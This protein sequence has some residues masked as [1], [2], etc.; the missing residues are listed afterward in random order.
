[1]K[2][3]RRFISLVAFLLAFSVYAGCDSDTSLGVV[4]ETESALEGTTCNFFHGARAVDVTLS[5]GS[6]TRYQ[7]PPSPMFASYTIV[8][9]TNITRVYTGVGSAAWVCDEAFPAG[10][11]GQPCWNGA[12]N[13]VF[14]RSRGTPRTDGYYYNASSRNIT[15]IVGR[16]VVMTLGTLW[17]PAPGIPACPYQLGQGQPPTHWHDC[18]T[19]S[20]EGMENFTAN[21][22]PSD[23]T[24]C[25]Q[26]SALWPSGSTGSPCVVND[27]PG[28]GYAVVNYQ[29][30]VY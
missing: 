15:D 8:P 13:N 11:P 23:A 10:A 16:S 30:P 22:D 3:T 28:F 1:M 25:C 9:P 18:G 24:Q 12:A 21:N 14:R 26:I 27:A 2:L 6:C 7:I 5:N 4:V 17:D 29:C 19:T 20:D